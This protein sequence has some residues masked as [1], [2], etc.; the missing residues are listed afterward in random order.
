MMVLSSAQYAAKQKDDTQNDLLVLFKR[1]IMAHHSV[2]LELNGRE[3]SIETGRFAKLANG[4]VM[5]RYGDTMVL[6]TVC[7]AQVPRTDLDFLPLTVE[8]REKLLLLVKSLVDS[9]KEK[10][11]QVK[12]KYFQPD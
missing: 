8:Y 10:V 11:S 1:K 4:S 5:V 2:S 12:K 3:Y 9:S 6:V 7:A